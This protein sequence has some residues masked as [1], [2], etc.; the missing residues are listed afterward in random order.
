MR[1]TLEESQVRNRFAPRISGIAEGLVVAGL[2]WVGGAALA[3]LASWYQ[4]VLKAQQHH[5]LHLDPIGTAVAGTPTVALVAVLL[6]F[7]FGVGVACVLVA[8]NVGSRAAEAGAATAPLAPESE[9]AL[10]RRIADQTDE[11]YQAKIERDDMRRERD[12]LKENYDRITLELRDAQHAAQRQQR[13][14]LQ[15]LDG[16][17]TVENSQQLLRELSQARVDRDDAISE[18]AEVRAAADAK[19]A[20]APLLAGSIRRFEMLNVADLSELEIDDFERAFGRKPSV[21]EGL[22][23]ILHRHP[24]LWY[25]AWL[26]VEATTEPS[27]ATDWSFAVWD[28]R[29][30]RH[31]CTYIAKPYA[32]PKSWPDL[33]YRSLDKIENE[34]LE[35]KHCYNVF[36]HIVCEAASDRLLLDTFEARCKDSLLEEVILRISK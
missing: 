26:Q 14:L 20:Q 11:V 35:S 3:V 4:E 23:T 27:R 6:V 30:E 1:P 21:E 16:R 36:L 25:V 22:R 34:Y 24:G 28:S 2:L 31:T 5:G 33:D 29:G 8:R 9:H 17:L 19:I 12:A 7:V 10:K 32:P 18:I 13:E 15:Q